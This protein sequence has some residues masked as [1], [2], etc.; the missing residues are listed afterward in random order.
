MRHFQEWTWLSTS[1]SYIL[2]VNT[3][4]CF[5]LTKYCWSLPATIPKQST[6]WL[7]FIRQVNR[8]EVKIFIRYSTG[9]VVHISWISFWSSHNDTID[10]EIWLTLLT[11][12][13]G[14]TG[15]KWKIFISQPC[16]VCTNTINFHY[17]GHQQEHK[18]MNL[19]GILSYKLKGSHSSRKLRYFK[20]LAH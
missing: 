7:R 2:A 14:G 1:I 6:W 3:R 5:C 10:Y 4:S 13:C 16:A 20:L 12:W 18:R 11:G 15:S 9:L 19:Y 8:Q 17:K